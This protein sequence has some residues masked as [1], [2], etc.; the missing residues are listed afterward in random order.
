MVDINRFLFNFI[1][2]RSSA[3]L[4]VI[5]EREKAKQKKKFRIINKKKVN[6]N[7]NKL[8]VFWKNP[9]IKEKTETNDWKKVE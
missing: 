1:C 6:N 5:K 9:K 7:K 4:L 2:K 8:I 3:H